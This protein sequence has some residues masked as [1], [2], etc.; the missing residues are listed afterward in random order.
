MHTLLTLSTCFTVCNKSFKGF[1]I[2]YINAYVVGCG[3]IPLVF[4]INHS[5]ELPEGVGMLIPCNIAVFLDL[6][7]HSVV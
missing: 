3:H 7:H 4:V 5:V 2:G 6:L 1:I